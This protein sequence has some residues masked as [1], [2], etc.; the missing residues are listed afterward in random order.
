MTRNMYYYFK[1]KYRSTATF[2]KI[3]SQ[4]APDCISSHIHFKTFPRSPL[5]NSWPLATRDFSEE[6]EIL[7]RTLQFELAVGEFELS[8]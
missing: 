1:R 5:G 7:H 4:D 2:L 8:G 3:L 6:Q